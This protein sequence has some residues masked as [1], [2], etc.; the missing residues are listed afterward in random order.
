[1]DILITFALTIA[2]LALQRIQEN[3]HA[4]VHNCLKDVVAR[5]VPGRVYHAN[6]QKPMRT[7]IQEN[8]SMNTATNMRVE[9]TVIN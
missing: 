8:M 3:M 2:K 4:Y 6:V 7:L 1:M 5:T 9:N